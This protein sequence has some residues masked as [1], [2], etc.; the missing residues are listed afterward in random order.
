MTRPKSDIAAKVEAREG[1]KLK[2]FGQ[3]WWWVLVAH[4]GE[5]LASS[6][7]YSSPAARDETAANLAHQLGVR[8]DKSD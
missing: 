8:Y 5:I 7:V 1:F 3:T 6:E 4:N 2:A